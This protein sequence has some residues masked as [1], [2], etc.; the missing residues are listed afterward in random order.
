MHFSVGPNPARDRLTLRFAEPVAGEVTVQVYDVL[1][2]EARY[3]SRVTP[4]DQRTVEVNL[5]GLPNRLY[6][7]KVRTQNAVK[8]VR[9]VKE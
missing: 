9:L 5:A 4:K 1:G 6:L 3:E 7:L 8:V 2:R